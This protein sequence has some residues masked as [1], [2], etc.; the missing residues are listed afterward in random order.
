MQ[1]L[2]IRCIEIQ[3]LSLQLIFLVQLCFFVSNSLHLFPY[4][5]HFTLNKLKR[6]LLT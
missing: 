1:A 5:T 3:E 4:V 2:K 6:M